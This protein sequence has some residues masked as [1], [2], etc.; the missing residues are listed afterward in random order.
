MPAHYPWGVLSPS[1]AQAL[2]TGQQALGE[3]GVATCVCDF[4]PITQ[5]AFDT[6]ATI[7]G[8]E[9]WRSLRWE[10]DQHEDA[11]SAKLRDYL[12]G[13]SS[14]TARDYEAA[15]QLAASTRTEVTGWFS[16]FDITMTPSAPDVALPGFD[17]TGPSTFNRLWTLLGM[18]C[19]NV[20][21]ALGEGGYPMGSQL[22]A[23]HG[24]GALLIGAAAA[25]EQNLQPTLGMSLKPAP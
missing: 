23:P 21:G 25:L 19:I 14:I 11:L 10:F 2:A 24:G 18:P 22:I 8:Y 4:L 7:Q 5:A 13:D 6:H 9:A 16:S 20:P 3:S 15:Q 17:S 12:R 1:A